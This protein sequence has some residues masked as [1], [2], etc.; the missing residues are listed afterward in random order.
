MPFSTAFL[1]MLESSSSSFSAALDLAVTIM[2]MGE[3]ALIKTKP[4]FGYGEAGKSV[5]Q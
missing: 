2:E 3:V 5:L 1:L 4:R